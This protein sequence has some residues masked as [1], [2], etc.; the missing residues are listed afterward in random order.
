VFD[1]GITT[2]K[3]ASDAVTSAKLA[4]DTTSLSKITA[5]IATEAAGA[6]WFRAPL[7]NSIQYGPLNVSRPGEFG[8]RLIIGYDSSNYGYIDCLESGVSPR[9][10]ALQQH[11]GSVGIGTSTPLDRLHIVGTDNVVAARLEK[12]GAATTGLHAGPDYG[13]VGTLSN[14]PMLFGAGNATHGALLQDG[15]FGLGTTSPTADLHIGGTGTANLKLHG[16]ELVDANDQLFRIRS[17]GNIVS[18]DGDD[19][20]GIGTTTPLADLHIAGS[21]Q[22]NIRLLGSEL[23]D[24][25]DGIFRFRSGGSIISFD[26]D[27][28][29]GIGTLNPTN[30]LEVNGN[31]YTIGAQI[32]G[33]GLELFGN[34]PFID[35]RVNN[36]PD[37]DFR[38]ANSSPGVL[39]F[40]NGNGTHMRITSNG[41]LGIGTTSPSWKLEVNGSAAK[42]GG[43]SWTDSSDRRL[44]RN[45]KAIENPLAQLLELRGVSYEWRRPE[46]ASRRPG[47]RYGFIAQEVRDIFPNWVNLDSQGYLGLTLPFD[48]DALIV[49]AFREQQRYIQKLEGANRSLKARLD[50]QDRINQMLQD[51]LA[52]L[53]AKSR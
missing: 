18:F 23:I 2:P 14:H 1:G 42:P 15:R 49:E 36:A 40:A 11:G 21:G 8:K 46:M 44:K 29:V 19:S 7:D 51:R 24:T 25:E 16:S 35:F 9:A 32:V 43:G 12:S 10:L 48:F 5:H 4:T 13:W 34:P 27:D 37:F 6:I 39:D 26:G 3:L 31:A 50:R 28:R 22:A 53:E 38:V 20:I 33:G 47:T 17:G 45:I 30:S 52:R 41:R